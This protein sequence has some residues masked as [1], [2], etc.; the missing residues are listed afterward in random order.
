MWPATRI[1]TIRIEARAVRVSAQS[2][3]VDARHAASREPQARESVEVGKPFAVAMRGEARG[4]GRVD[5]AEGGAHLGAHFE[6]R[7]ADGG[8]EPGD[9]ILRAHAEII[10][11]VDRRFEDAGGEPAPSRVGYAD[12]GAR[13]I[14]EQRPEGNRR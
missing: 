13:A 11:R 5:R 7:R 3:A 8:T 14:G 12:R 6:R 4:G 10:E 9:E 1:A 2:A